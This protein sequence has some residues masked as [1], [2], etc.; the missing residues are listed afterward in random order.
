VWRDRQERGNLQ[1]AARM[2][3]KSLI[4][5][6]AGQHGIGHVATGHTRDDQAE[7]FLLRL[8]RGSGVDGLCAMYAVEQDFGLSWIRP[9]L[10]ARRRELQAYLTHEGIVW[11]EDPSNEDTRFERIRM[12]QALGFLEDLG[13]G[14]ERL[15]AT[16]LGLQSAREGL[17]A[18]TLALAK[19]AAV[20]T[21]AGSVILQ[22]EVFA[23]APCEYRRRLLAHCLKW[24][25]CARYRPRLAALD[26][27]LDALANGVAHTL[28]GCVISKDRKGRVEITREV[29]GISHSRDFE[30]PFD[31]RWQVSGPQDRARLHLAPLG[32]AGLGQCRN[33]RASAYSRAALLSSPSIWYNDEL[34][35]APLADMAHG[36]S[37]RL[38]GG[39]QLFFT[40]LVTH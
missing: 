7:T 34:I 25:S 24:V 3:R 40:S 9:L 39:N 8:A 37:C 33:W 15:S 12:R 17:E 29:S 30:A 18:A 13:L 28:H 2:A 38:L 35:A 14:V 23:A 19:T 31:G 1:Q 16:A 4:A 36:W 6:W 21:E 22:S 5:T 20:P 26:R 10:H 27:G 32:D 11:V